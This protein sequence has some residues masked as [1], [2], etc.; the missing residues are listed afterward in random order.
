M[1][2]MLGELKTTYP[3][4]EKGNYSHFVHSMHAYEKDFPVIKKMLNEH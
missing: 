3:S 2:K 1:D 4:L